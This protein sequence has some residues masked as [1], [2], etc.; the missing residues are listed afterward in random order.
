MCQSRTA[1][2]PGRSTGHSHAL[3]GPTR[4]TTSG[5]SRAPAST[6]KAAKAAAGTTTTS[7]HSEHRMHR[8]GRKAGHRKA[9]V[10]SNGRREHRKPRPHRRPKCSRARRCPSKSSGQ[11]SAG[12]C[13][14]TLAA[15]GHALGH[16]PARCAGTAALH[17][18][19]QCVTR[20]TMCTQRTHAPSA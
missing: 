19:S 8:S 7:T 16:A 10:Q 13:T 1:R 2:I 18:V 4:S 15:T 11:C 6:A 12:H 3:H 14:A 17:V 5:S 20:C 9:K